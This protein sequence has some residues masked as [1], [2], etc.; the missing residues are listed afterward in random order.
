[1][2]WLRGI[3][4]GGGGGGLVTGTFETD[5]TTGKTYT[6]NTGIVG[7]EGF[8][9]HGIKIGSTTQTF[10]RWESSYGDNMYLLCR[11]SNTGVNTYSAFTSTAHA[12]AFVISAIDASGTV[13]IK[14]PNTA[15][16][17]PMAVTW[18]AY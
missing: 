17:L 6:I 2:P 14:A 9:L 1:M 7:L 4:S 18:W 13:T 3:A 5:S 10:T 15:G 11:Y 8:H 12:Y 16:L